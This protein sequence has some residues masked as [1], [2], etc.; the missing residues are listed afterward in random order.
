MTDLTKAEE[1]IMQILWDINEGVV[2]AVL[3]HIPEPKPAYNTVS[4]I[5]RILEKKKFVNHRAV[6]KT[7]IYFPIVSKDHYRTHKMSGF[8]QGYFGNNAKSLL[9]YFIENED[10]NMSEMDDILKLIEDKKNEKS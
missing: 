6:G 9:S 8:M 1:Q 5:V 3:E 2:K 4:T 7:H 10:I